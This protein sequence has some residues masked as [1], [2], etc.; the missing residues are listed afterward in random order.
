[1]E[2]LTLNPDKPSVEQ[3]FAAQCG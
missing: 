3:K 1:M 2:K